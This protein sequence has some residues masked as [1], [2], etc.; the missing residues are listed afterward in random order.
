MLCSFAALIRGCSPPSFESIA[1]GRAIPDN[2][3]LSM[4]ISSTLRRHARED[5]H[6]AQY[7][8]Q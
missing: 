1:D 5:R 2:D 7:V 3:F 8:I 4:L 6:T